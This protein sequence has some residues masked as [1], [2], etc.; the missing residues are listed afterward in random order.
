MR[1]AVL[2][3]AV[4]F[5][6]VCPVHAARGE[7]FV[8]LSNGNVLPGTALLIGPTV[9]IQR[10]DGSELKISSQQFVHAAASLSELYA[11]RLQQQPPRQ[12]ADHL[13][14]ARWALRHQLVDQMEHALA[15]AADLDPT[16]PELTHLQRQHQSQRMLQQV[17][18]DGGNLSD[19]AHAL[20]YSAMQDKTPV[21]QIQPANPEVVDPETWAQHNLS[22]S[23]LSV[24]ANTVQPLLIS[25][26]GNAGCHRSPA[27]ESNW[28]LTHMGTHQ[29]PSSRMTQLN[30]V[31]TLEQVDL[32]DVAASRLLLYAGKAHGG[33]GK[34]GY[35][36]ADQ[37]VR[38]AFENWLAVLMY[39]RA[40]PSLINSVNDLG[41]QFVPI[42]EQGLPTVPRPASIAPS[43]TVGQAVQPVGYW[44]EASTQMG[45]QPSP[46]GTAGNA[47]PAAAVA[48]PLP[49]GTNARPQRLPAV[50]NPVDPAIFNRHYRDKSGA[51]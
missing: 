42:S 34:L 48:S 13:A 12:F 21:V 37:R 7:G 24:Y 27:A 50:N 46:V 31:R 29:R 38:Q 14:N 18:N 8:L 43:S 16:H 36:P 35:Q 45:T 22:P 51:K 44:E 2:L 19:V 1:F 4:A 28:E 41:P 39:D 49:V 23:V 9:I 32:S 47:F 3:L 10:S 25:R 5:A 11:F 26:C 20:G 6:S 15:A 30:V 17:S 40:Q 33:T